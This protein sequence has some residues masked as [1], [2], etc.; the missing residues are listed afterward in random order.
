MSDAEVFPL[1]QQEKKSCKNCG[2]NKV[3]IRNY[4]FG[5]SCN[6]AN[7]CEKRDE[8]INDNNLCG[9]WKER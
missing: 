8:E 3:A 1:K 4:L 5:I 9:W 2:Y 7:I 6:Y